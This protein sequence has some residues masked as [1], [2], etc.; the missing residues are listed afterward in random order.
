[1]NKLFRPYELNQRLVLPPDLRE[2]LPEDHLAFCVSDVVEALA[3]SGIFTSSE[4][5]EGRGQPPADPALMGK[6][7][8]YAYGTGRPSS[9]PI[10]RAT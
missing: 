8:V 1:M 7:L 9:R 3:L 4:R 10:E 2:W 6:L 5:G